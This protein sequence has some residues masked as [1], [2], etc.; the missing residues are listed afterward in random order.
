VCCE[1]LRVPH[2]ID[3]R[4]TDRGK[5]VSLTP[6]KPYFSASST[7]FCLRLSKPQVL[8]LPERLGKLK[9]F[10]DLAGSQTRDLVA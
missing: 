3:K 10:N 6:Q 1:M 8:I 2:C 5:V 4:F 9:K 7:H